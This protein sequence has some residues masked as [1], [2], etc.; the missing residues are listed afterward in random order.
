MDHTTTSPAFSS[1]TTPERLNLN[2]VWR[3]IPD[4]RGYGETLGYHKPKHNVQFWLEADVPG[5]VDNYFPG[6]ESYEGPMW[7]VRE[8]KLP[9]ATAA[10][11]WVLRFEAVN[12]RATVWING[13]FLGTFVG[14]FLPFEW[15]LDPTLVVGENHR[16]TVC[17]DNRRCSGE[18]P[19][20]LRGWRT[21]G[22][23]LREVYLESR[24]NISSELISLD[25]GADGSL[26]LK[27]RLKGTV[28]NENLTAALTVSNANGNL[29]GSFT[30]PLSPTL[31]R[32]CEIKGQCHDITPW[33]P[34]QPAL[35]TLK[36]NI[37][38]NN[39]LLSDEL[40]ITS[41]FRTL[42]IKDG[43]LTLN[44]ADLFIKGF[45]RHD[46][47]PRTG[48]AMDLTT[49]EADLHAIKAMGANFVR[50]SHYPHHPFTLELCDRIGLLAMC[51]IPLYWWRGNNEEQTLAAATAQLTDLIKRDRHHPSVA[52]WGV[53]NETEEN[54]PIVRNGNRLLLQHVKKLDPTRWAVHASY[55]WTDFEEDDVIALTYYPTLHG[56]ERDPHYNC[57]HSGERWSER[58]TELSARYPGKP[59]L[60]AEFGYMAWPG[61]REGMV[62]ELLQ[63]E[64]LEQEYA[65]I[66]HEPAICGITIWCYADHPWPEESFFNY[67]VRS[68]YGVVTR[69]RREKPACQ[70]VRKLFQAP[71]P[72][73]PS[74]QPADNYRIIMERPH[75]NDIPDIPFPEGFTI[76]PMKI[77]D[78]GLWED[79]WRD[80]EPFTTISDGLFMREFGTD[81]A[82]ITRRCF[83]I[84]APN[85]CAVG[86]ISSWYNRNYKGHDYGRIH[87]VAIRP[88][89][90]GK[91]LAKAA[92]S[93][94]LKIMAQWHDRAYLITSSGRTA[95]IK[96]YEK[97]GF[98]SL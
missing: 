3:F 83:L 92:L 88:V 28:A 9:P 77:T 7:F 68:P 30:T 20:K 40:T 37:Y 84:F 25:A 22:G 47:S 65:G 71:L 27:F 97:F 51:E 98:V 42:A 2:G 50:L 11:H 1:A 41:G 87:W 33:S 43:R 58:L 93:F 15:P 76:R 14:G 6:I 60:I 55:I 12:Y 53:S 64:A 56:F 72:P 5:I 35:Y 49:T 57:A 36:L 26:A 34:D 16:L 62:S 31:N 54:S 70:V 52:F 75:L 19:G 95:A 63:A 13:R 10:R 78:A 67:I 46:D 61:I 29:C 38:R 32:L 48:L 8:F 17:V 74:P 89:W 81:P 59:I 73:A 18:V 85:G 45:N 21:Q 80:A 82:A 66:M 91:G 24:P 79:I 94:A 23:I 86:T 90:Q 69:D 44:G 39:T 4:P 96:L